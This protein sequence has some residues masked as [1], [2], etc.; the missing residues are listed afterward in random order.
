MH[1]VTNR[2]MPERGVTQFLTAGTCVA[3]IDRGACSC[4][5]VVNGTRLTKADAD[6]HPELLG[7]GTT[8]YYTQT[9][10]SLISAVMEPLVL[11]VRTST[12]H[13][14]PRLRASEATHR[15]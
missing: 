13:L 2:T 7:F 8:G 12:N 4:R 11:A 14:M 3:S 1:I 6:A 5:V 15:Y 9:A 10:D